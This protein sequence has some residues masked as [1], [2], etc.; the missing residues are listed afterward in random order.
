VAAFAGMTYRFPVARSANTTL[1]SSEVAIDRDITS[2]G[3]IEAI[4]LLRERNYFLAFVQRQGYRN[5]LTESII[6]VNRHL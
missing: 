3:W 2:T 5:P 6:M 4:L 1:M